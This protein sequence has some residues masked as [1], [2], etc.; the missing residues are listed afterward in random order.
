M[1]DLLQIINILIWVSIALSLFM[2]MTLTLLDLRG[3]P[4]FIDE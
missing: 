2:F 4:L 3:V 1:S